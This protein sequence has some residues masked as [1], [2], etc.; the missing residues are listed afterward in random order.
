MRL[1]CRPTAADRQLLAAADPQLQTVWL[2]LALTY[3]GPAK[4]RSAFPEVT[5]RTDR[6]AAGIVAI[7]TGLS[8]PM[9]GIDPISA[10]LARGPFVFGGRNWR[11]V[12]ESP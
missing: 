8:V 11:K 12:K 9:Y 6:P 5:R 3:K 4:R 7:E 10:A 1:R 2:R